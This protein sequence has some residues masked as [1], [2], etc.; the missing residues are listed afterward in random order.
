MSVPPPA[1]LP[2]PEKLD[3]SVAELV[4]SGMVTDPELDWPLYG[5]KIQLTEAAKPFVH[6]WEFLAVEKNRQF[7]PSFRN[8]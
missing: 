6:I 1:R 3:E 5:G 8:P 4:A 7:D 2:L